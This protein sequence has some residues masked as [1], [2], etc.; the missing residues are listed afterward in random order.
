MKI[1]A[2]NIISGFGNSTAETLDGV[3]SNKLCLKQYHHGFYKKYKSYYSMIED[4]QKAEINKVNAESFLNNTIIYSIKQANK[5]INIDLTSHDTGII[6]STTKGDINSISRFNQNVILNTAN[7]IGA[8]LKLKHAP[9]IISNA[10]SSG[11]TA[12]IC[13]EQLLKMG[14]FKNIFIVGFDLLSE[15]IVSGFYSL[16]ALSDSICTPFDVARKGI[17]LGEA[18]ATIV[19]SLNSETSL[20]TFCSGHI[21]NDANHISGPSKTGEELA[22]AIIKTMKNLKISPDQ[23][24]C[25]SAHGTG[26]IYNDDMESKAF[27]IANISSIPI[28]SLKGYFGHTLGAAGILE[29]IVTYRFLNQNLIPASIGCNKMSFLNELNINR[30][31]KET[32]NNYFI[33][34][35]SGF[36]GCNAVG[37]FKNNPL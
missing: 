9:F 4:S 26:T 28:F 27:E 33:K 6:F 5:E 7:E 32:S 8:F 10:C 1:I 24:A 19:V 21:S 25:V 13:A 36:G 14:K 20:S 22:Y 17:N 35:T 12:I 34:T 3:R 11:M 31:E 16:N 37:I 29:T 30:T 2:D 23:I 15:F 18:I